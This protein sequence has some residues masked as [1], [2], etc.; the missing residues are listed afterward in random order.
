MSTFLLTI[1]PFIDLHCHLDGA[2]NVE[3]ARKLA[4]TQNIM[5]PIETDEELLELISVPNDCENL[6]DF[7]KCFDFPLSLMQTKQGITEAFFLVAKEMKKQGLLYL[8]LR[9]APQLHCQK[10]LSQ[11]EVIKA[12]LKG[13]K[14]SRLHTNLILCCMRGEKTHEAN[15]ETIEMAK[16][17]LKKDNGVV[18]VDLAGAEAL[19]PTNDYAK[20]FLLAKKYKIPFTIHAGEVP[21]S[22]ESI[23]NALD[24][25][26]NRL[27]HGI[28]LEDDEKLLDY[29]VKNKIPLEIA[30]TSNRQTKA[31]SDMTQ[32]PFKKYFDAGVSVTINTDDPAISRTTLKAE[33]EYIQKMFDLTD[34]DLRKIQENAIDAAFTTEKTKKWLRGCVK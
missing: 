12:A 17:Y 27:G 9:F 8:E 30:P 15:I 26:A 32:Y 18:A 10:R 34:D 3:I 4:E 25:G 11:D 14:K 7:L 1:L 5:L 28:H 31:F 16:K 33:Y 19:F 6:N 21:N 22:A 23:K 20:E 13:I 29:V 24:F 2:I